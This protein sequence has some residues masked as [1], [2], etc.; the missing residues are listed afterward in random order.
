M[1]DKT[2]RTEAE[3][4]PA[5]P[6]RVRMSLG[7]D[8]QL[9]IPA[10]GLGRREIIRIVVAAMAGVAFL[11]Y[12]LS[13]AGGSAAGMIMLAGGLSFGLAAVFLVL[14]GLLDAAVVQ[15]SSRELRVT[16]SFPI[17]RTGAIARKDFRGVAIGRRSLVQQGYCCRAW[18]GGRL[19]VVAMGRGRC[20]HFGEGLPEAEQHWILN[21][22][23]EALGSEESVAEAQVAEGAGQPPERFWSAAV[24]YSVYCTVVATALL[25]VLL[26]AGQRSAWYALIPLAFGLTVAV[27]AYRSYRLE[28]VAG[29]WH[30][31]VVRSLAQPMGCRFSPGDV[32]GTARGLPD[33]SFFGGPR[34]FYNV[35]YEED[36]GGEGFVGF[37]FSSRNVL[38]IRHGV[39]CAL[40]VAE[41]SH[42]TISLRPRK[43]YG[44]V[45]LGPGVR[46]PA[47][48]E[49]T[50]LY[51]VR[52]DNAGRARRLLGSPV[53][54]AV[55]G[56]NGD[57][58]PPWVCISGGMVG[59][60]IRRRYAGDERAMRQFYDYGR[61]VR[62]AVELQLRELR[63][64]GDRSPSRD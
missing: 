50:Q 35:L 19:S 61:R 3:I 60:G 31:A 17:P 63:M 47:Q 58:P 34:Q 13:W 18:H 43:R 51:H 4:G 56:W 40:R 2:P 38:G 57:G 46:L 42:E 54:G 44:L 22:V 39:G 41:L 27:L 21:M 7:E 11:L 29:G 16:R 33:F 24:R 55:T 23:E 10:P 30:R 48:P 12:G 1:A 26:A 64:A 59:L 36:E 32:G 14:R 20:L 37:D 53:V 8:V 52:A 25:V 5:A 6:R 9:T 28:L 45:P 15:I 62:D 49:F